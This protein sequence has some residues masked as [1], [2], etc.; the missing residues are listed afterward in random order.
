M[1]ALSQ[2]QFNPSYG[3]YVL[4]HDGGPEKNVKKKKFLGAGKERTQ[5]ESTFSAA[6]SAMTQTVRK[7]R[8][9]KQAAYDIG[10]HLGGGGFV[11]AGL[12]G[13]A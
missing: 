4:Y 8:R 5:E 1:C 9:H 13:E 7:P 6:S 12:D 2:P 11:R 10:G 3:N